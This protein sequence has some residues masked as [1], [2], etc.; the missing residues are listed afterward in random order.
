LRLRSSFIL[1][2][3][4]DTL[5]RFRW[6][7][8][9]LLFIG[10]SLNVILPVSTADSTLRRDVRE[11]TAGFLPQGWAFFTKSPR[12]PEIFAY[13][14]DS[15]TRM[16]E[17]SLT[18]RSV[19]PE[20]LFGLDREARVRGSLISII[21]RESADLAWRTCAAAKYESC[22]R[23][24]E[25]VD[26]PMWRGQLPI[27]DYCDSTVLLVRTEPQIWAYVN[28]GLAADPPVELKLISVSCW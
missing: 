23:E 1:F 11:V 13:R 26:V 15:D 27:D 3:L 18:S 16:T 19:E 20:N 6:P 2:R 8:L 24:L 22:L 5:T 10:L 21:G 4:K 17:Q 25:T 14:F 9:A 28:Q 12:D 7:G